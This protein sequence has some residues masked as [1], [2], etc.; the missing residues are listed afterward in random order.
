MSG[1]GEQRS[2]DGKVERE[3]AQAVPA[4]HSAAGIDHI[5]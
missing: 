1:V 3:T 5:V 4:C 2:A